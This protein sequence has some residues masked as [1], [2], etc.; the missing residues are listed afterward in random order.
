MTTRQVTQQVEAFLVWMKTAKQ[1]SLASVR[2]YR[3][4]LEHFADWLHESGVDDAKEVTHD[5]IER[6][7]AALYETRTR[8]GDRR[9]ER[10]SSSTQYRRL[11]SISA[12]FKWLFRQNIVRPNPAAMIELP[13][14]ADQLP[15]KPFSLAE[16]EQILAQPNV[17]TPKGLR[18]RAILE[19]LFATGVRRA[20]LMRVRVSDV[21]PG[22][23][24]LFVHKGKGDKQ[25]VVPIS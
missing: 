24:T 9:G 18:D 6:Y 20:E 3:G 5:L 15:M 14:V 4:A 19:V 12:W 10:L 1:Y 13:K 2:S 25:R 23:R 7:Q 8:R 17:G 16:V 21:D 22:R 11:A